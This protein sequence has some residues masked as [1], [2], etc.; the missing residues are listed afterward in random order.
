MT[1]NLA[2]CVSP[3]TAAWGVLVIRIEDTRPDSDAWKI[4]VSV[5]PTKRPL[6]PPTM[7]TMTTQPSSSP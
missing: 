6:P 5:K 4:S 1:I 7:P 2:A 3:S